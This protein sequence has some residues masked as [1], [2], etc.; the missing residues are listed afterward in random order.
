MRLHFHPDGRTICNAAGRTH[1]HVEKDDFLRH[2]GK[3][4]VAALPS[5]PE[6][7]REYVYEEG[8]RHYISNGRD[9]RPPPPEFTPEKMRAVLAR[10]DELKAEADADKAIADQGVKQT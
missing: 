10:F 6:G 5:L 9:Q 7:F 2:I 4:G 8:G 3:L 1:Y